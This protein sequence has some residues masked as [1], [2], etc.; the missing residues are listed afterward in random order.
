MLGVV[1]CTGFRICGV[2]LAWAAIRDSGQLVRD[3]VFI[4]AYVGFV[5]YSIWKGCIGFG[6]M[7]AFVVKCL[8]VVG[9]IVLDNIL[10]V[11]WVEYGG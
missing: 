7:L 4:C 3:Y 9:M 11:S 5:Q 6:K 2:L 8:L 10:R 1:H